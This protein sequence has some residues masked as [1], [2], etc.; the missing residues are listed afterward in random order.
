[1]ILSSIDKKFIH[2]WYRKNKKRF[3]KTGN[4]F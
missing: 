2:W 1:M 4:L 3:N